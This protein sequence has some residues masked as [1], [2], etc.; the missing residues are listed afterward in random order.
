V[1]AVVHG[2]ASSIGFMPRPT[3]SLVALHTLAGAVVVVGVAA[4]LARPLAPDTGP[5]LD[6]TTWFDGEHLAQVAAYRGPRYAGAAIA[7]VIGVALPLALA[8]T[9][10][11]QALVD[12]LVAWAGG[13]AHA[14]R[15]AAFVV[16]AAVVAMDVARFPVAFWLSYVHEGAFGFRTQG[17]GGWLTDWLLVR[18][19]KWLGA[20][21]AA[22][23]AYALARRL[24]RSWPAI[25]GLGGAVAA[26]VV[27]AA[28][29]L[30]LEP[31]RYRTEPLPSGPVR[32][33]VERILA[34]AG[35][36]VDEIVVADAS[37]RT[38][39]HNAYVSGLGATRRIVLFDNLIDGHPP[40]EVG[41][42]LAHEIGHHQHADIARGV[43][44]GAAGIIA[45]V[46]ALAFILRVAV[47]RG[48]LDGVADPRGAALTLALVVAVAVAS[49]P[50]ERWL[51]R[52]AEAAA[53][54]AALDITARADVYLESK[55]RLARANLTD[56]HPPR[57]AYLLWS[58]HPSTAERLTMGERWPFE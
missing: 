43:L 12:R 35:E 33:E 50:V 24:P 20:G 28:A 51:S 25:V 38:T 13:P 17:L 29:P 1:T 18:L 56:P 36:P 14:A 47:R 55:E 23:V 44:G 52:R 30:V 46:Y 5:V 27:V 40:E 11:G 39:K 48:C 58:T 34:V 42:V 49:Q 53:D 32:T 22:A 9:R 3:I 8:F 10:P 16:V 57:W 26:A 21:L 6:A 4:Q 54:Y 37:R 7:L 15:A 41:L 19:P 45:L 2:G 31:L